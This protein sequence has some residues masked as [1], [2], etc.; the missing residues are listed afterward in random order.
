MD[1]QRQAGDAGRGDVGAKAALLRLPR[2]VLIEI[3]ETC[4]AQRHDLGMPSQFDQFAHGN[5]VFFVGLMRMG[6]DRAIDVGKSPGDFQQRAQPPHPGRD[7]EDAADPG[8]GGAADQGVEIVGE[9][10]KI[11]MAMAVDKHRGLTV[12][13]AVGSI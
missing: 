5:A 13:A 3:V 7:R 1:D 8:G 2:A 6:A 9:I 11:E 4:F 10:R 12:Q